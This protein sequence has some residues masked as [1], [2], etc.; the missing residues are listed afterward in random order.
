[1]LIQEHALQQLNQEIR[2]SSKVLA[3]NMHK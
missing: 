3:N 1:M 2:I